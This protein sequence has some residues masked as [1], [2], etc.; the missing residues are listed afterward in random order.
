MAKKSEEINFDLPD[1]NGSKD[2]DRKKVLSREEKHEA[3]KKA[4]QAMMKA[5][6]LISQRKTSNVDAESHV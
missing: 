3:A 2:S 5:W 6:K 1:T 4:N